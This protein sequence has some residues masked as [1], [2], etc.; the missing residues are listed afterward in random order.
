MAQKPETKYIAAV[1]RM[2]PAGVYSEKMANPYR[3][4][5]PD[6]Y[7]EGNR[8]VLDVEYKWY[9]KMPGTLELY[10]TSKK[11]CLS[12]LQQEWLFRA[13]SNKRPV[14]VIVGSPQGGI[15][16]PELL[17][18]H[19]IILTPKDEKNPTY[20]SPRAVAEWIAHQVLSVRAP[21]THQE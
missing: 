8:G 17:W 13:V 16:L 10:D 1:G 9:P 20:L 6:V 5:H 21:I 14:A 19:L 15:I 12:K 3:G 18:E 4:G 2:L 7:Y 11:V